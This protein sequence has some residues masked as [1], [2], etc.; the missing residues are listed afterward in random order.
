[1]IKGVS[2]GTAT[3]TATSNNGKTATV[4]VSVVK[5]PDI[6]DVTGV[7]VSPSTLT[8]T[9]GQTGTLTATVTPSNATDKSVTWTSSNESVAKVSGGTVT[10][11]AEG[12]ATITAK[13]SNGKT[14]TATV[15]VEGKKMTYIDN[16]VYFEKPSGWGSTINAY[17]YG[18]ASESQIT[19]AWPGKAMKEVGDGVYAYEFTTDL[20]GVK[21]IFNDGNNQ[22]PGSQQPGFEFKNKG[23]YTTAGFQKI[24]EPQ[25]DAAVTSVSV[26]PTSASVKVGATTTL[27]ATVSPSNATNK[28]VAW[29]SSNTSVATVSNGVVTGVAKGTATITATSNNGKTATATITVTKDDDPTPTLVNNSTMSATSIILGNTVILTGAAT[30]G[31]GSYTYAMLYKK[32]SDSNWTTAQNFSSTKTA[33]IKPASATTYDVCVKV[34]DSAGTVEKK[35]F[36]LKVTNPTTALAN[37][38]K[39]SAT[40]INLGQTITATAAATGGTSPYTYQIVYKKSTQ[41]N[42]TTASAYSTT[43]T[44]SIKPASTGSYQVC[45]KVKD[46]KGTEVKKFFD[47]T[48]KQGLTNTSKMSATSITLGKT[49]TLTGSATG[50]T[51]Y[52]NFAMLYKK[53]SDSSWT[54]AQ[55]FKPNE[56]VTIKPASAT[57]YDVCVKVQD[58]V[59][60]VEKKFFTL[61]VTAPA[62]VNN[63]TVS[64]TTVTV[65][66]AVTVKC[67]ATGGKSPYKY[68]VYYKASSSDTWTTKQDFSTTASVSIKFADTGKKD[69]CVKVKDS[70]GTVEKKYFTVTVKAAALANNSTISA[71]TVALGNSI[72]VK[73]VATGG[74]TP[75]KYAVYYKASS[76]TTWTE[77]QAFSTNA[78]VSIKFAGTGT[79]D[80]CVKVKDNTGTVVKKYF[81]VTVNSNLTNNS[82]VSATSVTKGGKVT[83]K[84]AAANGTSP[85]TYKVE[86]MLVGGSAGWTTISNTS[87]TSTTV[88]IPTADTYQIRVTVTD[89]K[90]ATSVKYFTVAGK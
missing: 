27:S 30:G 12:T 2:I 58:S 46:K 69:I 82:T 5:N 52:Y 38:S 22:A 67:A 9:A 61:K 28:T 39:V 24:V 44:A 43:K 87:S 6:V 56:T 14:A 59:G 15:I 18:G 33:T 32:A 37:N 83:V 11:V 4:K 47:I 26:S 66:N 71:T 74:T 64:P 41:S 29:S 35:F 53:T 55:G 80:V 3:I 42:W 50:G 77:K 7:T 86:R 79:K 84:F 68:A 57:T 81:T 16:G 63:S 75:Y 48:V 25:Q 34:K 65:G 10:A 89:S 49:V 23:Y 90:K 76:A 31:T 54:T 13:T 45:I 19:G 72:T 40:T 60:T 17:I 21:V 8:V 36:T 85:Y 62:L 70:A 51:G 1:M 78:S 73:G 20:T 88:A